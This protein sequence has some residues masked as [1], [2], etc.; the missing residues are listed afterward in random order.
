[1]Q[2]HDV[3]TKI[4]L[5]GVLYKFDLNKFRKPSPDDETPKHNSTSTEIKSTA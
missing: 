5:Q 2:S 4:L 3:K 1:M